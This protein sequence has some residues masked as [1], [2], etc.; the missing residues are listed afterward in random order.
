MG[1]GALVGTQLGQTLVTGRH[2]PLVVA[3]AAVS[4]LVLFAVVET[5]G[6]SQFFGCTP[7]GPAAWGIVLGSSLGATAV[8]VVVPSLVERFAPGPGPATAAAAHSV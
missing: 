3:T 8:G 1:L 6:V 5:P 2:S 7:L 4:A